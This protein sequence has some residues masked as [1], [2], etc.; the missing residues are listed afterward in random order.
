MA[1][2]YLH[3]DRAGAKECKALDAS[4]WIRNRY[5]DFCQAFLDTLKIDS[6]MKTRVRELLSHSQKPDLQD[7]TAITTPGQA[8][9][10]PPP[11]PGAKP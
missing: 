10:H 5:L 6:Y 2:L 7:L 4:H 3:P 9:D 11:Q 1:T 8:Q